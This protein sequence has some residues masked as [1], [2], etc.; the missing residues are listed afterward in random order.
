MNNPKPSTKMT[1]KKVKIVSSTLLL[2][3]LLILTLV[4]SIGCASG[5]LKASLGKQVSLRIGQ[6]AEIDGEQL[7][8]T[9]DSVSEDSRCPKG[10][11]CIRAGEVK[12]SVTVTYKDSPSVITLV[13]PGT[14]EPATETYERYT[15]VYSVEPYPE[16]GRPISD[17]DYRLNLTVEK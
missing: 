5:V 7:S 13:Q 6:T 4:L 9:F 3:S 8:I 17:S 2:C 11:M 10:V 15:L 16:A 14:T 1:D 12:C